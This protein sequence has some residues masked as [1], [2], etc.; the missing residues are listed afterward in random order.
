MIISEFKNT[1]PKIQ[2]K[3]VRP[4]FNNQKKHQLMKI[5]LAVKTN[6]QL[7]TFLDFTHTQLAVKNLNW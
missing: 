3:T 5:Q 6:C 7:V 4:D 2:A 1:E